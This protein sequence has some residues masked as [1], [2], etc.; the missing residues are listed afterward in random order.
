MTNNDRLSIPKPCSTSHSSFFLLFTFSHL[1]L[2]QPHGLSVVITAPAVFSFTA[3]ICPERHLEAAQ[4]LGNMLT[5]LQSYMY[6]V[7]LALLIG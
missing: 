1:P 3:P 7:V 4:I 2:P 6:C 5:H